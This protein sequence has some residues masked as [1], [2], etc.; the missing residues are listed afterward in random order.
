[1]KHLLS[2]ILACL[3][4]TVSLKGE[5]HVLYVDVSGA[6]INPG[7]VNTPVATLKEA[8]SLAEALQPSESIQVLIKLGQGEFSAPESEW[9]LTCA[10]VYFSGNGINNTKIIADSIAISPEAV[11][12]FKDISLDAIMDIGDAFLP[13]QQVKVMSLKKTTGQLDG[14]WY[15][16]AGRLTVSK[17]EDQ[18]ATSIS[19][20]NDDVDHLPGEGGESMPGDGPQFVIPDE[21]ATNTFVLKT[22]D[23]MTGALE[24]N[25]ITMCLSL[26]NGY[27]MTGCSTPACNGFYSTNGNSSGGALVYQNVS[28]MFMYRYP[29]GGKTPTYWQIYSTAGSASFYSRYIDY[30]YDPPVGAWS[31]GTLSTAVSTNKP[32]IDFGTGAA[33]NLRDGISENDAATVGQL[34]SVSNNLKGYVDNKEFGSSNIADNASTSAKIATG[35]ITE[36]KLGSSS[37]TAAKLGTY[38]VTVA[39]LHSGVDDRY[40]NAEGDTLTGFLTLVGD[41]TNAMHAATM[42]YVEASVEDAISNIQESFQSPLHVL[43]DGDRVFDT[44][45]S[46]ANAIYSP[47]IVQTFVIPDCRLK[48]IQTTVGSPPEQPFL[49]VQL[50]RGEVTSSTNCLAEFNQTC[51]GGNVTLNFNNLSLTNG[52]YSL[53]LEWYLDEVTYGNIHMTGGYQEYSDGKCYYNGSWD[54]NYDM[55]LRVSY[56][57]D[58][59]TIGTGTPDH[60]IDNNGLFVGGSVEIDGTTYIDGDLIYNG[61]DTDDRYVNVA[62]DTITG[63]LTINGNLT[64]QYTD[65]RYVNTDG[66]SMTGNLNLG[67]NALTNV[68]TIFVAS[69][70]VLGAANETQAFTIKNNAAGC[71]TDWSGGTSKTVTH[72]LGISGSYAVIITPTSNPGGYYYVSSKATDAFTVTTSVSSFSFDYLIVVK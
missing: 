47:F 44:C 29:P 30:G 38:A 72:N 50:F 69:D 26:T 58:A 51:Y 31:D 59:S 37:V 54:L 64:C 19:H 33:I 14:V 20:D 68:S 15:D 60:G 22:G 9:T 25:R 17:S 40:V 4:T 16:A 61:Q 24:L 6:D 2:L 11:T 39:K 66:D 18:T 71:V 49:H 36:T 41:P 52:S 63:N 27:M 3:F 67:G 46:G 45:S 43:S 13:V 12:G 56:D 35:A 70:W 32:N 1:M 5:T 53:R 55:Y 57:I 65:E 8:L 10:H 34:N 21:D 28:N 7:T 48:S 62:G 42:N 23:T